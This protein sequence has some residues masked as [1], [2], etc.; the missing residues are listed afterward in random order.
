M[1]GGDT[2]Q[3]ADKFDY[4]SP[5]EEQLAKIAE[6]RAAF[7]GARESFASLPA[8]REASLALTNLEQALMWAN[9]AVIFN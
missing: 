3:S 2:T 6:I 9:K 4:Q 1:D 8:S 7:K 5:S